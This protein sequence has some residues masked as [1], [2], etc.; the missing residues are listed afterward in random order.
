MERWNHHQRA[1]ILGRVITWLR[2]ASAGGRRPISTLPKHLAP[3]CVIER[4]LRRLACRYLAK[5]VPGGWIPAP[6]LLHPAGLE[7]VEL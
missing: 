5:N 7:E 2:D 3:A 1:Q 6:M 4:I